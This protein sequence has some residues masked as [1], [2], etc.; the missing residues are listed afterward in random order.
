MAVV[1]GWGGLGNL[2]LVRRGAFGVMPGC[3]LGPT[4][5]AIEATTVDSLFAALEAAGA[6][7]LGAIAG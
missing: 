1:A 7:G 2:E 6:P 5:V 4:F 3:D